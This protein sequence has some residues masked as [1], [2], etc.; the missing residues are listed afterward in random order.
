M[1][2]IRAVGID[3]AKS[4]FQVCVWMNDGYVA[5]NKK[6]HAPDCRIPFDNSSPECL[7]LWRLVQPVIFGEERSVLW[8]TP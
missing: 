5:W 3:I 4:V 1:N 8:D 6:S 7:S 2:A